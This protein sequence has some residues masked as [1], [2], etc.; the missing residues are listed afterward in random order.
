MDKMNY[1]TKRAEFQ[2]AI[3]KINNFRAK[4]LPRLQKTGLIKRKKVVKDYETLLHAAILMGKGLSYCQL[5]LKMMSKGV[6]MSPVAW[7]KQMR[8]VI[9][10]LLFILEEILWEKQ[11]VSKGIHLV[12]ATEFA[13]EGKKGYCARAHI[14]YR[15]GQRT[16]SEYLITDWHTPERMQN[17]KNIQPGGLYIADRA[18]GRVSQIAYMNE[19]KADY[20]FRITPHN[21]SLFEDKECK[22]KIDFTKWLKYDNQ[23]AKCYALYLGKVIPIRIIASRIPEDQL[24][25][26]EK[27]RRRKASKNQRRL[28]PSTILFSQWMILATSLDVPAREL[29]ELY[30]Q[31]WQI[32]ILFKRGKSVF[33]FRRLRRCSPDYLFLH[34]SAWLFLVILA[35]FCLFA[36]SWS[37]SPFNFFEIFDNCFS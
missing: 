33:S 30:R 23:D 22:K 19:K 14:S 28:S 2:E 25:A 4:I 16:V 12:D 11:S 21:I 32:E 20:L 9:P 1:T 31:R 37:G 5:S 18:Y 24:A 26:A 36:S 13:V 8:K 15:L 35:S 34:V 3:E 7:D 29:T 27:R 6:V 10:A 17:F